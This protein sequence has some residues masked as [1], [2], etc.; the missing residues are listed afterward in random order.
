MSILDHFSSFSVSLNQEYYFQNALKI[1]ER[2]IYAITGAL[3]A[4]LLTELVVDFDNT[5]VHLCLVFLVPN[6]LLSVLVTV[7]LTNTGLVIFK[8]Y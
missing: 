5:T 4:L 6:I 7:F 1:R 2:S 8:F 3:L